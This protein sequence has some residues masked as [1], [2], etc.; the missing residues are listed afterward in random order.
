VSGAVG[1]RAWRGGKSQSAAPR[2]EAQTPV[3]SPVVSNEFTIND[4][5]QL[6]Q[7]AVEPV[8]ER[9]LDMERETTG[10]VGFNEDRVTPVFTN[11]DGRVVESLAKK[12]DVVKAGQ[13]LLIVESPDLIQAENDLA[14]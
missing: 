9:T 4:E 8:A 12:G 3:A 14:T 2:V 11:C 6:R 10:R 7:I 1:Y 5:E 13:P